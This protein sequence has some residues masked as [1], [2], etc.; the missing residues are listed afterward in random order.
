MNISDT[1]N[2]RLEIEEAIYAGDLSSLLK[3]SSKLHG[4]FCPGSALG[5]KAGAKAMRELEIKRSTGMEEVIAIVEINSCFSDGVQIVTGCTFGNNALIYRDFGKTAFTLTKR[6]GDGVRI[7]VKSGSMGG[8]GPEAIQRL[9]KA[10]I[11]GKGAEADSVQRGKLLV[12]LAFQLLDAP[13]EEVFDIKRV[14][15]QVPAHARIY[16]SVKCSVC[17]E[18]VMEPRARMKD[19]KPICLPCAN[20]EYYQLTGDGISVIK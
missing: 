6:S 5:V 15:I 2:P 12:E 13:D 8:Q 14:K 16:P 20:Q 10:V 17:G 9:R 11:G 18:S 19:G 7:C 3:M 1:A 4:H